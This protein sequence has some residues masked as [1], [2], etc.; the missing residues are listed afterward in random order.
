MPPRR[1]AQAD[2]LAV[3]GARGQADRARVPGRVLRAARPRARHLRA[4]ADARVR[5]GGVGLG[6]VRGHGA[7]AGLAARPHV[8]RPRGVR[9]HGRARRRSRGPD[10][11]GAGRGSAV[12][13]SRLRRAAP[14]RGRAAQ[15]AERP[16]VRPRHLGRRAARA[17]GPPARPRR[18]EPRA[19]GERGRRP[20][21]RAGDGRRA[22]A[23]P[24]ADRRRAGRAVTPP[25]LLGAALL[26]WGWQT[27]F[28]AFGVVLAALV[29]GRHL[30]RSRWDLSRTDFNRV[31]DLSAVLLVLIAIYQF[32]GTDA[33][34]AVLAILEWLPLTVL[35]L[36]TCQLYSTAGAVDLSIFFWSLRRRANEHPE[37]PGWPIDLTYPY[38]ALALLS[39]SA[40]NVRTGAF[41]AG[42]VALAGWALW[43]ARPRRYPAA[44]WIATLAGAGAPGWAGPVGVPAGPR[45]QGPVAPAG[46]PNPPPPGPQPLQN[47]APAWATRAGRPHPS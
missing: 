38:V 31:S 29:D 16:R 11:G 34:R 32:V 25:R 17:R 23:R 10:A 37:E 22:A 5:G 44:V 41:F 13:R 30:V 47:P 2:P 7:H 15:P 42:V 3:V 28:L 45:A 35:P 46:G 43:S 8:R 19:G 12:P 27:G 36:V 33:A 4:G 18:A 9:V 6:V 39:A 21:R 14:A 1:S 40:A 26:F 24:R 20:R